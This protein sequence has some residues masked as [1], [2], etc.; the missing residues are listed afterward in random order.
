MRHERT[1]KIVLWY[2]K[3]L[4]FEIDYNKQTYSI[5]ILVNKEYITR[6]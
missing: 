4:G 1:K 5:L 3:Q 2:L 6:E